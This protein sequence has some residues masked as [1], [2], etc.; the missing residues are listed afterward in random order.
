MKFV[1]CAV[2]AIMILSLLNNA[3]KEKL[4]S[5]ERK[6]HS[7]LCVMIIVENT[8]WKRKTAQRAFSVPS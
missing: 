7:V 3:V 5:D 1:Q 4:F 8:H 2:I 6:C